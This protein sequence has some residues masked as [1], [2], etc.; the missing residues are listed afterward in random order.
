MNEPALEI[1]ATDPRS[2]DA[3]ELC[4][5]QS[6]EISQRYDHTGDG[7]SPFKP[8]D[9][10]GGRGV[11]LI[12]KFVGRAVA[13]GAF[14]PLEEERAEIKRMFVLPDCRG[15]GY[16]RAILAELENIARGQGF[17]TARLETGDRQPE[18]IRL[19]L[20]CGYHRIPSFGIYE[21]DHRSVCFEKNLRQ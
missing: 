15:R 16:A 21:T 8:E 10:L 13:C 7:F 6:L 19:Y 3:L 11:F 2:A 5:L 20:A 14:R 17:S 1:I 9:V 12:G 18:A 4:R